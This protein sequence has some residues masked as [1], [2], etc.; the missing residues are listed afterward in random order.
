M[1]ETKCTMNTNKTM[2]TKRIIETKE[3]MKYHNLI[4]EIS[5]FLF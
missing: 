4:F 1:M 2:K 5:P 3:M